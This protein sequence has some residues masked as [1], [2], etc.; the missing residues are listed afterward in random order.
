VAGADAGVALASGARVCTTI[1]GMRG[2][3]PVGVVDL[4]ERKLTPEPERELPDDPVKWT[5]DALG[6]F[7]WSAQRGIMRSVVQNRKTA[8]QSCHG[9]GK[10]FTA[11]DLVAW[12]IEAHPRGEALAVTTAPS[13]DQVR[14]I[15][16]GEIRQLHTKGGLSGSI[17]RAQNPSW[18]IGDVEVAF[19][20]KPADYV[21]ENT[22]RTMFQGIHAR[23]LLVVL[24]EACGIPPWL[25]TAVQTL[26]TNEGSRILAI[27]NPDDPTTEFAKVCSP[28]SG[29]NVIEVSAFDT[30]NFTD[31]QVPEQ[32]RESLIG[33]TYVE[34]AERSWGIDSP[35]YISKV[36]GK[37]PEVADDVIISP[38]LIREA[39][40]RDLSG[41]A[42]KDPGRFGMD[43]ADVGKDESVVML[44]RAGMIRLVESW[45]GSDAHLGQLKARAI[46]DDS[47][48]HRP[49]QIDYP[50][51][52]TAVYSPLMHD[53]YRV[54]PFNGGEAAH[55]DKRFANRNA[56][57]WWSFREGLEAGRIDLDPDDLVLAAQL[58]QRKWR[59]DPSGRRIRIETKEEMSKRGI[60]SPDRADAAILTW[61]Q[62]VGDVGNPEAILAATKA[63][64]GGTIVGDDWLTRPT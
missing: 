32:L 44:N 36:L 26:V 27:G 64:G 6:G 4:T 62:G 1:N 14:K 22:A 7:L 58:Q 39:H 43:V 16:W 17:T 51:V 45:K 15:L 12:W 57:A 47:L 29:Y 33:R 40:E 38:K 3:V 34:E 37:F 2:M 25:W 61:Y 48:G 60:A 9:I 63:E 52:G 54:T 19:G 35:L 50:G 13:G 55:D 5:Q 18:T 11:A 10:S 42:L 21:D 53:G 41:D 56:E 46:L 49:M 28:G 24:D 30:P 23:Y 20:R 8:V 59:L 31:E